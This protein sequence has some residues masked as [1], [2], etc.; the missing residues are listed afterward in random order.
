MDEYYIMSVVCWFSVVL[1]RRLEWSQPR[2]LGQLEPRPFGQVLSV[3]K[4]F[5]KR[6]MPNPALMGASQ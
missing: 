4:I 6:R 3:E 1:K 5:V 2:P